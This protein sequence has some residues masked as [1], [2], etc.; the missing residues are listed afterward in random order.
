MPHNMRRNG[1]K[2]ACVTRDPDR[3]RGRILA[4]AIAEFAAKGLAGARVDAIARRADSNKRMIY[5]YFGDKE[6]L[7][8]AVL[9][10][11]IGERRA[12]MEG[13]PGDPVENLPF[14]FEMMCRDLEWVRLLG[15][16]A[17]QNVGDR[18]VEEKFRRAGMARAVERVRRG[19]TQGQLS[20]EFDGCFLVLAKLSLAMFPA[21]FPHSTR[22]ITGKS[23][24]NPAFQRDYKDFLRRF[25]VAFRPAQ[26]RFKPEAKRK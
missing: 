3:T 12:L 6:G 17:L 13:A 5:H 21:A 15:W 7:F 25:A 10:W 22:L 19:Q 16:E 4:A 14:R 9:R 2:T 11:K 18:V 20:A 1:K 26:R 8:R 23:I 24:H